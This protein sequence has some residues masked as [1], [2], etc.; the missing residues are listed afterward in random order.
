M[1]ESYDFGYRPR[2]L[3]VQDFCVRKFQIAVASGLTPMTLGI[4]HRQC[5]PGFNVTCSKL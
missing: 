1:A 3:K 2:I 5:M 4:I